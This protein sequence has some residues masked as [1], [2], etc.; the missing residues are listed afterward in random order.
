MV[1]PILELI[2]TLLVIALMFHL[3]EFALTGGVF[4]SPLSLLHYYYFS[5]L[6]IIVLIRFLSVVHYIMNDYTDSHF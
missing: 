1:S 3:I 5:L 6:F 2:K 4:V